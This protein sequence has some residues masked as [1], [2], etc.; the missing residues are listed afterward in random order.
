MPANMTP[1]AVLAAAATAE[2]GHRRILA[3]REERRFR[4]MVRDD[5][6]LYRDAHPGATAEE[7]QAALLEDYAAD[8]PDILQALLKILLELL[9]LFLAYGKPE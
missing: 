3:S 5:I 8:W 1:E 2:P 7:I 9:P 4:R 6:A